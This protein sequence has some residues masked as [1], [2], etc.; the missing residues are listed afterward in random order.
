M[1]I[2]TEKHSI[3]IN[4]LFPNMQETNKTKILLINSLMKEDDYFNRLS[5][6]DEQIYPHFFISE[7]GLVYQL[8]DEK[9]NNTITGISN[10]D[11][12]TIVI[13]IENLG[14]LE[15]IGDGE[16]I[17]YSN[18]YKVLVSPD[19][20]FKKEFRLKHNWHTYT[21]EQYTSLRSLLQTMIDK[22]KI[23][24]EC[25]FHI[26]PIE[27]YNT[28]EGIFSRCNICDSYTD[29][30]PAFNFNEIKKVLK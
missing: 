17:A 26:F 3:D 29:I 28:Y 22:H 12:N 2:N 5:L 30:S 23:K 11:N 8:Y 20:V 13:S 25:L 1:K 16:D 27:N 6:Q 24:K 10:I 18:W 21:K 15:Q 9:Y 19:R 4:N 14:W 7:K